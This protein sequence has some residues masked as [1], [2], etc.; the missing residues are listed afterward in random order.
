MNIDVVVTGMGAISPLGTNLTQ[1]WA[2]LQ[3]GRSG[4]SYLTRFD[5][6]PF[7]TKVAAQIDPWPQVPAELELPQFGQLALVAMQEALTMAGLSSADLT[8]GAFL[9]ATS[10]GGLVEWEQFTWAWLRGEPSPV[11][12]PWRWYQ[13][14]FTAVKLAQLAGVQGP[15]KTYMAACASGTLTIGEAYWLIKS[16][17]IPV[18][19]I[20]G[21]EAPLVPS[22]FAG[23]CAV[24]AMSS[25]P[26]PPSEACCPFDARRDG[27][28][29][30]EG[31]AFLVLEAAEHARARGAR[32][33][34]LLRG[35]GQTCDAYHLTAPRPDGSALAR[36]ISLALQEGGITPA[37][38][39]YINAHGTSTPLND[40]IETL[41]LK[42][43]LGSAAY[44]TPI[45][46]SKSMT[47]HLLGAAGAVEAVIT[48]L[49]L[50][51]QWLPPTINLKEPDPDCDLDYIPNVGRKA[52][53]EFALSL[54]AG[55]GGHNGV[56]L[57]EKT[58]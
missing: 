20:G 7:P 1:L 47:G 30:G 10:R 18:V 48:I 41:A 50:R 52:E 13:P 56:V 16:G 14:Q 45:S 24:R 54:S 49:A 31:A 26:C 32:P 9:L 43:A 8:K 12:N 19:I 37:E 55:F 44:K 27:Y 2:A 34:A 25:R 58:V 4:I 11:S 53:L 35:F 6:E 39:G 57:F 36:A 17:Q 40:K 22:L 51:Q 33:L 42:Q 5:P 15:V 28:V 3:T 23:T 38:L 21:A 46:S 29:M